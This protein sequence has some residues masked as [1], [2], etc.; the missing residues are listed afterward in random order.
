MIKTNLPL[1]PILQK[2]ADILPKA[3]EFYQKYIDLCYEYSAEVG[4]NGHGVECVYINGMSFGQG[5]FQ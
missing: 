1:S 2:R 4:T 3:K 5:T